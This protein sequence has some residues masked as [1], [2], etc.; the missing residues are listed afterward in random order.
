MIAPR[1]HSLVADLRERLARLEKSGCPADERP[2]STGSPALDRLLPAGGLIRGSLVEY[3]SPGSGSGTGTLALAA[4]RQ[5]CADGRALVVDRSRTS[6]RQRPRHGASIVADVSSQRRRTTRRSMGL[7]Q[8]G[9]AHVM[10]SM[11]RAVRST[12]DFAACNWRLG[13]AR[14]ASSCGPV[15]SAASRV[16]L[17][18]SETGRCMSR[19]E[20]HQRINRKAFVRG[21]LMHL[22]G[23]AREP[24]LPRRSGRASRS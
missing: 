21:R 19:S 6:A 3:L 9:A 5:A 11:L 10:R 7:D 15:V 20:M 17:T 13:V 12:C 23:I 22:R 14:W 2:V 1:T 8:R 24:Q 18:C 16:G 4:A